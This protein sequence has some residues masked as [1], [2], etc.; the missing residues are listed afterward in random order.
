MA[1]LEWLEETHPAPP[2][3]PSAPADRAAVRAAALAI[4][5]DIHPVNNLRVIERLKQMGHGQDETTAWMNDWMTRGFRT[6]SALIPAEGDFAFGDTPGLADIC[7]VP[8]LYNAR[9]WGCDLAPF[10]R[11]TEIE[12]RCLA[13]AA[14]AAARPEA[15]PDAT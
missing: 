6:V 9:R 4:A 3:L 2:L 10:P 1:I 15:Q 5:A 11:L 14:F 8:Q 7:L 12:A 13:L